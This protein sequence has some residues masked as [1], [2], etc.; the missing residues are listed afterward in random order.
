MADAVPIERLLRDAGYDTPEAQRAAR[1]V[2]EAQRLTRPGKQ[3][4]AVDKIPSAL[5][6]LDGAFA[7]SCG[8][9]DCAGRAADAG[10]IAVTV[11]ASACPVCNG[12]NNQRAATALGERLS[13]T[14]LLRLLIVGGTPEQHRQLERLLGPHGIALRCVDAATGSHARRDA[15]PNLAWAQVVVIWGATPLPHKVSQLYAVAPA[16]VRV[17]KFARR[18]IEALCREVLRSLG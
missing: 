6:A 10:L 2:L 4:M 5:A 1:G 16:G 3:A 17:V 14:G 9:P 18:G 15:G 11:S 8:D 7:L 13:V 12:S